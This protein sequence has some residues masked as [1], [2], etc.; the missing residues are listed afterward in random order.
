MQTNFK[1][2]FA[3]CVK[4]AHKPLRLAIEDEVE[5]VCEAPEIGELKVGDLAGIRVHKF[6]FNRQEY[7]MAYRPRA[8]NAPVEFFIID[9][10]QVGVHEK[11]YDELKQYLRNEKQTGET[12]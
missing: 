12:P 2:P 4:K 8:K 11:F 9:F 7:L 10:Y 5:V 6:R 1:R 3:Q